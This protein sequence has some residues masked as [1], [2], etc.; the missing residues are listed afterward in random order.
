MAMRALRERALALL[1]R[2]DVP[3][4]YLVAFARGSGAAAVILMLTA[5][6]VAAWPLA[7]AFVHGFMGPPA[8]RRED[9]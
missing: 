5:L 1:P 2:P 6:R 7:A 4:F 8:D 3:T 9:P